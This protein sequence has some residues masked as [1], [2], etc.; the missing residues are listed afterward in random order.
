M[1]EPSKEGVHPY[2]SP[3]MTYPPVFFEPSILILPSS[4]NSCKYRFS[5]PRGIFFYIF[6]L[7]I[8]I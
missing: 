7:A 4:I 8:W 5:V 3:K 1:I 2:Y 6:S